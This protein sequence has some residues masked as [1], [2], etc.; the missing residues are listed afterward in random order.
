MNDLIKVAKSPEEMT[1]GAGVWTKVVGFNKVD[2]QPGVWL[3]IAN[4]DSYY[5]EPEDKSMIEMAFQACS[6]LANNNVVVLIPDYGPA[7]GLQ[8]GSG[9]NG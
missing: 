8:V 2:G 5:Y 4:G 6:N 9:A 1:S 7:S 3:Q